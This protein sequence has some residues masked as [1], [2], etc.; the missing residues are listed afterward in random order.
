MV[1]IRMQRSVNA[2]TDDEIILIDKDQMNARG[3]I[4]QN[5]G[6]FT[7]KLTYAIGR[8]NSMDLANFTRCYVIFPPRRR[9]NV[10][11]TSY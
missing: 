10:K 8:S 1:T 4:W 5:M 7:N 2:P 11:V 3:R 6:S 9:S